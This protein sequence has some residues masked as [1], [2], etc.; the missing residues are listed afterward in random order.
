MGKKQHWNVVWIGVE[1]TQIESGVR[2][3]HKHQPKRIKIHSNSVAWDGRENESYIVEDDD[4]R[5]REIRG[6]RGSGW[7]QKKREKCEG[8]EKE[9]S[10]RK[11][12]WRKI[13]FRAKA[14]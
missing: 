6:N 12:T 4:N 2:I 3:G 9:D 10:E 1:S 7:T 14:C 8:Y 11:S 13:N 5:G